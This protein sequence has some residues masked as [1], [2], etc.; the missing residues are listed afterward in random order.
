MVSGLV[1]AGTMLSIT[2]AEGKGGWFGVVHRFPSS[3]AQNF[4]IAISAFGACFLVTVIV[5]LFTRPRPVSELHNLVYGITD[6]PHEAHE[7]WYKRPGPL[8]VVVLAVVIVL[9]FIFW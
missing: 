6:L 1:A 2:Q 8:A 5:S 4:W 7:P 9:N 3:M